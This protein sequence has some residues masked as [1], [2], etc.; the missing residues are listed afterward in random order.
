[1]T[2]IEITALSSD[3][4][5]RRILH[6]KLRIMNIVLGGQIALAL[7][8]ASALLGISVV[9]IQL[10]LLLKIHLW[11]WSYWIDTVLGFALFAYAIFL[12][13]LQRKWA[14]MLRDLGSP[15]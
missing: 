9:H 4:I 5:D 2:R 15:K 13:V 1:M 3:E 10:E 7:C 11:A 6:H 12:M 8:T 14:R